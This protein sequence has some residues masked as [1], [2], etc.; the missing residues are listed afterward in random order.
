MRHMSYSIL[1][2]EDNPVFSEMMGLLLSSI[3][4]LSI[5]LSI[6]TNL[7]SGLN[8]TQT[9]TVDL[10]FLDYFLPDSRGA[11][12]IQSI[13]KKAPHIPIIVL[14]GLDDYQAAIRSI[15]AG[16]EDYLIKGK[17][18]VETLTRSISHAIERHAHRAELEQENKHLKNLILLESDDLDSNEEMNHIW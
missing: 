2:I 8:A 16:A 6:A 13:R 14:T 17:F 5:E 11:H 1:L 7:A 4:T 12:S 15:K 9:N 10:I 3:Q 18:N